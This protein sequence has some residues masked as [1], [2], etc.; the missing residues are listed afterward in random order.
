MTRNDNGRL[1]DKVVIVTGGSSGIGKAASVALSK[2]GARVVIASRNESEGASVVELIEGSGGEAG[3]VKTDVANS[4]EVRAM[5]EYTVGK[6]GRLD[7]AFNNAGMDS[8]SCASPGTSILEFTEED[9]DRIIN[10]NLKGVWLCMKYELPEMLKLGKGAIV[11]NSSV[12]GLVGIPNT[13][14]YTASKHGVVG[15]TKSAAL[16]YA[17]KGIRINA[18]CPGAVRT[19]M[20][21]RIFEK[22]PE[23][24]DAYA[25]LQ[26]IGRFG[27]P[28]EIA[29]CV[30]WLCSDESSLV[31]GHALPA[32]GGWTAQ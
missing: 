11:N 32:E 5:V 25:K 1:K 30:V 13:T 14:A 26:P 2:E 16:E 9:W 10:V 20:L 28:E 19:P 29:E 8:T 17:E 21:E 15:L 12:A 6:Y 18:V 24:K 3:F 22:Q 4:S 23:R 31:T 7:C 27:S